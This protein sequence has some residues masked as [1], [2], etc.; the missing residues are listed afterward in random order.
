MLL[1]LR[2]WILGLAPLPVT[3]SDRL[4]LLL[5]GLLLSMKDESFGNV[6]F[7]VGALTLP[8]G[9]GV[10]VYGTGSLVT[11]NTK[12]R[13]ESGRTQKSLKKIKVPKL[14]LLH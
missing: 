8:S 6:R 2:L 1:P 3:N 13:H 5:R 4:K 9:A 12:I 11:R 10:L 14:D 7:V